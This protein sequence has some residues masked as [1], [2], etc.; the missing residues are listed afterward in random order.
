MLLKR[1]RVVV[2]PADT[3]GLS[4]LIQWTNLDTFAASTL[5]RSDFNY[6]ELII[7]VIFFLGQTLFA[8]FYKLLLV[9]LVERIFERQAHHFLHG[10]FDP[11]VGLG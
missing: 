6:F 5:W 7:I 11:F 1:W 10:Y 8:F 2:E 9:V 4:F 3:F